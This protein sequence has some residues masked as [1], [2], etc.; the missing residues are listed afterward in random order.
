MELL[1]KK[2]HSLERLKYS[3]MVTNYLDWQGRQGYLEL[4]EKFQKGTM[5]DYLFYFAMYERNL[6]IDDIR[7]RLESNL[8]VLPLK[9]NKDFS[10][11]FDYLMDICTD[12]IDIDFEY[13][14]TMVERRDWV[15]K[16]YFQIQEIL[17][18]DDTTTFKNFT[19][20]VD[21]LNWEIKDQYFMLIESFLDESINF[22][23]LKKKSEAVIEIAKEFELNSIILKPTYQALGFSNFIHILIQLF[24]RYQANPE[25][26]PKLFKYWV[27][28]ILLEMK[29]HYS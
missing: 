28:K 5:E 25:M 19:E 22:L 10:D 7:S 11:K 9:Y 29:N 16:I 15:Q 13:E 21:Q 14:N 12:Y 26:S 1:K 24:D 3:C 4:L 8:I 2:D 27:R 17:K 20:L 23:N 18:D 6:L